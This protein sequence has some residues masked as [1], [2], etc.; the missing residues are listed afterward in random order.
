M[1]SLGGVLSGEHGDGR[2][3]A[4]WLEATYGPMVMMLFRAV[5]A[6]FDPAGIMNPGVL[7]PDGTTPISQL[8]AGGGAVELPRDISAALREIERH[9]GYG[10]WRMELAEG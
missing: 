8:K 4:P 1:L 7:L 10:R 2:L 6:A 9:G 3:R 5:K